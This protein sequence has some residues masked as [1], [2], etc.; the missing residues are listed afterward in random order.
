MKRSPPMEESKNRRR[1]EVKKE[2]AVETA[3][4]QPAGQD[5]K[6]RS[7]D[8]C[9]CDIGSRLSTVYR[10]NLIGQDFLIRVPPVTIRS[11]LGG[12]EK[13]NEVVSILFYKVPV[14]VT[15]STSQTAQL[16]YIQ[17]IPSLP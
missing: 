11:I 8:R 5:T 15:Y 14:S 2:R 17:L 16:K 3:D 6:D 4:L 13:I 1:R 7:K 12:K 9:D 10:S